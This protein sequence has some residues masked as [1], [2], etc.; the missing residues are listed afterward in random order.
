[1]PE[2]NNSNDLVKDFERVVRKAIEANTAYYR[3]AAAALQ[4]VYSGK[5]GYSGQEMM[6]SLADAYTSLVKLQ[7]QYAENLYE[8]QFCWS[9]NMAQ[10][11]AP[12]P[13][14]ETAEAV[15]VEP[16]PQRKA[17][18]LNSAAGESPA[19]LLRLQSRDAGTRHCRFEH[20]GFSDAKTGK[21]A[22]LSLLCEPDSFTLDPGQEVE[23]HLEVN[24][25]G[26]AAPGAYINTVTVHGYDDS[27]FDLIVVVEEAV[28]VKKTAPT[29]SAGARSRKPKKEPGT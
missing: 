26:N 5:S 27:I 2:S 1:M 11:S 28:P 8:L 7:L 12:A 17:M 18:T 20:T 21:A 23:A 10:H 25:P 15:Q 3:E 24:I 29:K 16:A 14:V 19:L 6:D 9:K 4:R 13:S 22:P